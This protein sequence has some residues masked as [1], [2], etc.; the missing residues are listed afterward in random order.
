MTPPEDLYQRPVD[1]DRNNLATKENER[2]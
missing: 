2:K 1:A